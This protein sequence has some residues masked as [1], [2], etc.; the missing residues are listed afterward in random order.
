MGGSN[1][2]HCGARLTGDDVGLHRKM[3]N[4]EAESF[5]CK[6]CLAKEFNCSVAYLDN[7]I[8]QFKQAGCLLFPPLED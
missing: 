5:L 1:C 8:L 3:I 4:R 2:E 7:R 6:A